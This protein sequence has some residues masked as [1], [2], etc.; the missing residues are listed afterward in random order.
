MEQAVGL[1]EKKAATLAA[2]ASKY[3]AK[4]GK[5]SAKAGKGKG[6]KGQQSEGS[7]GPKKTT[8]Y[9][10]FCKSRREELQVT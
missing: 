5:G 7:Q 9:M 1:L 3:P 6:A 2:K 4:A 8:G 10:L